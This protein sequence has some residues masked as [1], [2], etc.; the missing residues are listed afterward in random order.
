MVAPRELQRSKRIAN[1]RSARG[2]TYRRVDK[3]TRAR[4]AGLFRVCGILVVV[5][6]FLMGY[7]VLTSSLTGLAYAIASAKHQ[8]AELQAETMRLDDRIAAL[9]SDDRLSALAAKM[10]MRE[11]Q[12]FALVVLPAAEKPVQGRR[13]AAL[14]SLAGLFMPVDPPR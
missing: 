6:S 14:S 5:L 9:R 1:P 3:K 13:V 11:P 12:T 10:G 4:Y 2:A 8:R 7:V